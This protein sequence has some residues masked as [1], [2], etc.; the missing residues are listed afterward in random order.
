MRRLANLRESGTMR[1]HALWM[2]AALLAAAPAG[3][4]VVSGSV[5]N[6]HTGAPVPHAQVTVQ[7][8][9]GATVASTT[10]DG[11]GR[12]TL[13]LPHGGRYLLRV[14]EAGYAESARRF[15]V[16]DGGTLTLRT[17]LSELVNPIDRAAA[18]RGPVQDTRPVPRPTTP[19]R[20]RQPNEN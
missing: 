14:S 7:D 13:H 12:F 19:P 9:Q 6:A 4:Q 15:S 20:P 10:L 17:R 3:A 18:Q 16:D 5:T 11:G 8:E 2:A 1:M